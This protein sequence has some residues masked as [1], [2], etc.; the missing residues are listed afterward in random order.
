MRA[1]KRPP[2]FFSALCEKRFRRPSIEGFP[3]LGRQLE[4]APTR[5]ASAPP[6]GE[7][8]Y[9]ART[10]YPQIPQAGGEEFVR[11]DKAKRPG[12]ARLCY[13]RPFAVLKRPF[14]VSFAR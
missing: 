8:I 9:V 3:R 13:L 7:S 5:R 10:S 14:P 11:A 12:K 2:S 4:Y 1:A 6:G